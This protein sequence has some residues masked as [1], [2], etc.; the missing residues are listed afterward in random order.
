M[1]LSDS[2]IGA[3]GSAFYFAAAFSAF[4]TGIGVDRFGVK[5]GLTLWLALTG[6][7]LLLTGFFRQEY[8]FL[9]CLVALSG[10]GY[11][12]GNPVASKGLYLWFDQRV[13]GTAFGIRQAAVTA[14]AAVAGLFLISISQKAGPFVALRITG[15]MIV[16][17]I[18]FA[19]LFYRT[20]GD[21]KNVHPDTV[22][23]GARLGKGNF[24]ILFK[25][26]P[27]LVVSVA[28]A[29]LGLSQGVVVTFFILYLHEKLGISLLGA[30]SF[31]TLLMAS[32][33]F[34]RILWGVVSDRLF[35]GRRKPVLVIISV[36]VT[37]CASILAFWPATWPRYLLVL[38]IV[39]TGL[40]SVGWN[41]ISSVLVTEISGDRQ[42]AASV[43]LSSTIGWLG[44]FLGPIGFGT[45][46]DHS[47][48][49]VAWFSLSFCCF[50]SFILCL[51]IPRSR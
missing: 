24:R 40:S 20:P 12:M 2:Q 32:G 30:G 1:V 39:M 29:L 34:G 6:V 33:A 5:I 3:I 26:R 42:T 23:R 9:L 43:G 17:M 8:V 14:G 36:V 27:L 13:R 41:A 37:A 35:G 22:D 15:F 16:T 44:I 18:L 7:P 25:N 45:L 28:T 51:M 38:V 19:L 49:P 50:L 10:F 47:G 31:Y 46:L 11:G 4:P 21:G 48:Y